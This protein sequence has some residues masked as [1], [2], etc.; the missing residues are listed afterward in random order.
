MATSSSFAHIGSMRSRF[1]Y[2]TFLRFALYV[3]CLAGCMVCFLFGRTRFVQ[4]CCDQYIT[5]SSA[6]DESKHVIV[7]IPLANYFNAPF[8]LQAREFGHHERLFCGA[9]IAVVD[10]ECQT[11]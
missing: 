4:R 11:R 2:S 7:G 5:W 1:G 10:V 3:R 6:V 9:H 8:P